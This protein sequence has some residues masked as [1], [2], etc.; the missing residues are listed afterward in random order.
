MQ[1][2]GASRMTSAGAL[3]MRSLMSNQMVVKC[4]GTVFKDSI[5]VS[6]Y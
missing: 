6:I 4:V 2:C 5:D 3:F 1:E